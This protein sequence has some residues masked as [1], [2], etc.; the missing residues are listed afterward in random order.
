MG[1][2]ISMFKPLLRTNTSNQILSTK[3]QPHQESRHSCVKTTPDSKHYQ[4]QG[5]LGHRRLSPENPLKDHLHSALQ[6]D[7]TV[8]N[9]SMFSFENI[10]PLAPCASHFRNTRG[11]GMTRKELTLIPNISPS[12][13]YFGPLITKN[14]ITVKSIGLSEFSVTLT[15]SYFSNCVLKNPSHNMGFFPG[16]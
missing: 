2:V 7:G 6:A 15:F 12:L 9:G 8:C 4:A 10:S 1:G 5:Q 13:H 3:I 11:R 14:F 16:L